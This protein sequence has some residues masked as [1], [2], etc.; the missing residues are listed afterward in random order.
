MNVRHP[1]ERTWSGKAKIMTAVAIQELKLSPPQPEAETDKLSVLD[2][3][4]AKLGELFARAKDSKIK[5]GRVLLLARGKVPHGQ[6]ETWMQ[7]QCDKHGVH[8]RT[9]RRYM[10]SAEIHAT[11]GKDHAHALTSRTIAALSRKT[12]TDEIRDKVIAAIKTGS[13]MPDD[14]VEALVDPAPPANDDT[15]PAAEL[16]NLADELEAMKPIADDNVTEEELRV[17]EVEIV[18]SEAHEREE[19]RSPAGTGSPGASEEPAKSSAKSSTK[20]SAKSKPT[21][22]DVLRAL[23]AKHSYAAVQAELDKFAPATTA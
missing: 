23:V 7:A 19:V 3:C 11:V 16:A 17:L 5:I 21:W 18:K 1:A 20:S 14:E 6:F 8:I 22:Q 13:P 10:R 12:A 2:S 4:A 9:A 15:A